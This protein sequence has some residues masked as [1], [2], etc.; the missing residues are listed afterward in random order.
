MKMHVICSCL[1]AL[2]TAFANPSVTMVSVVAD[3]GNRT[4]TA[5]YRLSEDAIV[6]FDV[7]TNGV[8]IGGK[9]LRTL[10][11]DVNRKVLSGERTIVWCWPQMLD[12]CRFAANEASVRVTAWP[13]DAPP[14]YMVCDLNLDISGSGIR[15]VT[16][17]PD[18]D[19]LPYGIDSDRYRRDYLVARRIPAKGVKWRM[20]SPSTES[21]RRAGE[22]CHYV[23]FTNDFYIGVFEI[24]RGQFKTLLKESSDD[25]SE[26]ESTSDDPL[27]P[28]DGI[29]WLM[30]RSV[31]E[32]DAWTPPT[33]VNR[34]GGGWLPLHLLWRVTGLEADI[35]TDAEWEY[36]CR[37]GSGAAHYD[38][39]E[40]SSRLEELAWYAANSEGRLH[41]VG[42]KK[43]NGWGLYDMYGNVNEW[44]LDNYTSSVFVSPEHVDVNPPGPAASDK[45]STGGNTYDRVVRGG[46]C[47]TADEGFLRSASR[48][49][50]NI[51]TKQYHG[52]RVVFTNVEVSK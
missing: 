19:S 8:S 25:W 23:T 27:C 33:Y 12:G 52:F 18:E 42:E 10:A 6:T 47:C 1:F 17:Y 26:Y 45:D 20:G 30:I 28:M 5:R 3:S 38:G 48:V 49:A 11:G 22:D 51:S 40:D 31:S 14:N 36:A 46:G 9:Q 13:L 50:E 37:A 21:G 2:S 44:C 16:F 29:R 43:P 39:T 32:S 24:T 15:G 7:L 4:L 41:R 35:P 34:H